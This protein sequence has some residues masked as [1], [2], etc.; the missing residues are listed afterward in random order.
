MTT[1]TEM[2]ELAQWAEATAP[3]FSVYQDKYLKIAAVLR[4]L[5]AEKP[6]ADVR[7]KPVSPNW[8]E[9]RTPECRR[10]KQCAASFYDALCVSAEK[11]AEKV[12]EHM[13]DVDPDNGKDPDLPAVSRA[14]HMS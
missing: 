7:A 10:L 8:Q 4:A 13:I 6:A 2:L 5:A 14:S 12:F 9:C 1:A 3:L 11:P